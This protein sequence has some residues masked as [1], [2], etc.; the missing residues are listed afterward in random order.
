MLKFVRSI[1]STW[2]DLSLHRLVLWSDTC[3]G[4]N[5]NFNMTAFL[6]T[7]VNDSNL[8][9]NKVTHRYLW[10]RHS[11]LPNDT[12]F[13]HTEKKKK[14]AMGIDSAEEY[15]ELM[16]NARKTKKFDVT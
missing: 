9:I 7:L 10:S 6:I 16:K 3:G 11:F 15:I 2:P 1:A 12:D 14:Y 5:R 13:S 4:Q 8:S